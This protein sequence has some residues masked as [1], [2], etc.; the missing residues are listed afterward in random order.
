MTVKVKVCGITRVSDALLAADL[1]ASAIGFVFWEKSPRYIEPDCAREIA[2]V[3]PADVAP[4]G[5]FV[6]PERGTV[7]DVA[8]R[9]G[10]AGVQLHGD[11]S[12]QFCLALPY[13]V[14]KGVG[15]RDAAGVE[16]AARLPARLTVLLDV[17]DPV[18]KGG[19]GRAVD[20]ELAS[21]VA[22]QRRVF[23]AGGLT[24]ANVAEAVH[25]VRPYGI[26]VSSSLE[27]A[28]GI[29]DPERLRTFFDAVSAIEPVSERPSDG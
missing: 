26:D 28:P 5:V 16:Q 29:K 3:L 15:L 2:A 17:A 7:E 19:T 22:V 10:L 18:R 8:R 24:S 11:E 25:T 12:A 9:V 20:W 1:G 21:R 14:L 4:I 13:R 6:D 23:L 27:T